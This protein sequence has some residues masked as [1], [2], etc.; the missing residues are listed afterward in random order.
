MAELDP[1]GAYRQL[2]LEVRLSDD[3]T[4][5]NFLALGRSLAVIDNLRHQLA[6]GREGSIFL[7]GAHGSGK[8]HLLQACCQDGAG[9]ALYLP[10]ASLRDSRA[11]D[12]LEGVEALPRICLDDLQAVA[13]DENWELALFNLCNRARERGSRL[14]F[15][16]TAAPRGLGVNL[17]DLQSRLSWGEVYRLARP[18]DDARAQI[19]QFRARRRGLSLAPAV[20]VYI[21]SR[22]PRDLSQLLGLLDYLDRASLAEQRV[23]SVPFVKRALGW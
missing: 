11:A 14:V 4:F 12:V 16:A 8:T 1:G 3:A 9:T 18:D 19:L 10:L 15:A 22:A 7:H 2:A 17:A 21:V 13:G 20:A 6:P 23:L 5:D